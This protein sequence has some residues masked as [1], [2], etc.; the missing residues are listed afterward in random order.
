VQ[1]N[2]NKKGRVYGLGS[3]GVKLKDLV[4]S[5]ATSQD[6]DHNPDV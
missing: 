6:R 3:E 1:A 2:Y 4:K 5:T